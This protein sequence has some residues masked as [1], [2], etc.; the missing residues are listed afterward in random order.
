MSIL[1]TTLDH[2]QGS[3]T[4]TTS[5]ASLNVGTLSAS[6]LLI[7]LV[8]GTG[9]DS[10]SWGVTI[11]PSGSNNPMTSVIQQHPGI[12]Q[13]ES[14]IWQITGLTLS[15]VQSFQFSS[16]FATFCSG[17]FLIGKITG[18]TSSSSVAT[19]T[20]E[21]TSTGVFHLN[22]TPNIPNTGVGVYVSSVNTGT[23]SSANNYTVAFNDTSFD[24]WFGTNSPAGAL[25][26]WDPTI[27]LS[28]SPN[29]GAAA[30]VWQGPAATGGINPMLG[31]IGV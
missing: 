25:S 31:R 12:T 18:Y 22:T 27:T 17:S 7:C 19:A 9:N 29:A 10:N 6:D 5:T 4:S 24:A 2:A 15:G 30:A 3:N 13:R 1:W 20:G 16:P 21:T 11:N 28:G 26:N 23:S 14:S 8:A